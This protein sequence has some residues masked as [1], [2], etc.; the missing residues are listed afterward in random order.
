MKHLYLAD[1]TVNPELLDRKIVIYGC[2]NDGKKLLSM[3]EKLNKKVECFCDSNSTL[4]GTKILGVEVRSYEQ[5]C[6]MDD[7]NL[8]LAFHLY[9][10]ILTKLSKNVQEN[11]FADFLFEQKTKRKCII[12]GCEECTFDRAHFA[13]FLVERMFLG[14]NVETRLIHC[15]NCDLYYSDYRPTEQEMNRLYSGYR[16]KMYVAQRLKYEPNYRREE[17]HVPEYILRRKN[18]VV[19]FLSTYIDLTAI[20]KLLD[21]GGDEGQY[22]PEEFNNA[23]KYV[24][25]ISGNQT[26]SGVTLLNDVAE[27]EKR[28]WDLV[29]CMHL[30]EHVSEPINIINEINQILQKGT[31]LYIELPHQKYMYQ[32]SDV[33]INEHIN[34]YRDKTMNVIA[35]LCGLKVIGLCVDS[36][37]LIKVLYQK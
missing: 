3:L 17:Y 34:F 18:R 26:V 32:Y 6:E 15:M 19:E 11:L 36:E 1:G 35:E 2:G 37:G 10:Q 7:Y 13:P 24:Y 23:D 29:M 33:E 9:P 25:D 5:V 12:C 31:Y 22:I 30:L 28:N 16:D 4:W 21:Y 8:A 27:I 14:K 20:E